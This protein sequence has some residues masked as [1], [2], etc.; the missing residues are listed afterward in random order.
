MNVFLTALLTCTELW[1]ISFRSSMLTCCMCIQ[2]LS[3][4]ELFLATDQ[5]AEFVRGAVRA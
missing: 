1:L 5:R 4:C 3:S 2:T